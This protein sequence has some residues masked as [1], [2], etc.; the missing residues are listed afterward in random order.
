MREVRHGLI[1]IGFGG[2]VVNWLIGNNMGIIKEV[3]EV[4][5]A[6]RLYGKGQQLVQ[7]HV[8]EAYSPV[9]VTG[10]AETMGLIP[11]LAMDL[12]T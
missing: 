3:N 2:D 4:R 1:M 5:R 7:S 10:M 12:T 6:V 9:R 8:S 11:G